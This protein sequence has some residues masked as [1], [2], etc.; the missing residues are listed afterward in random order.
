MLALEIEYKNKRIKQICT[1]AS[2]AERK[3]G[4]RMAVKIQQRIGEIQNADNV[5]QMIRFGVGRCHPLH[6][7][8]KGLYAVDLVHPHRMVFRK[9]SKGLEIA[10][11][12]E[13]IDYH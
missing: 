4:L 2:V 8:M 6:G 11:I 9:K 1:N 13:V 10:V 3:Y 12:E 5:E 7:E